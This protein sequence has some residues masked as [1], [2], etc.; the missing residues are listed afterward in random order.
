MLVRVV[1]NCPATPCS[2]MGTTRKSQ[3]SGSLA[4]KLTPSSLRDSGVN[5]FRS[6]TLEPGFFGWSPVQTAARYDT[7]RRRHALFF[8]FSCLSC[9]SGLFDI[10]PYDTVASLAIVATK[11]KRDRELFFRYLLIFIVSLMLLCTYEGKG[12][13]LL[14]YTFAYK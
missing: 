12:R 3:F 8:L 11:V 10:G 7:R 4:K 2:P 1:V 14:G 5:F 6:F 13:S 9:F